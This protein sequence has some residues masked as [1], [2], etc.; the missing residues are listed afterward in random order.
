MLRRTSLASV[1]FLQPV[2]QRLSAARLFAVLVPAPFTPPDALVRRV[3]DLVAGGVDVVQLDL[4]GWEHADAVGVLNRCLPVVLPT[5]RLLVVGN[6][7]EVAIDLGADAMLLGPAQNLPAQL[8]E[9]LGA[10]AALGREVGDEVQLRGALESPDLAFVVLIGD[11]SAQ[12]A[13]RAHQ[14][15]PLAATD[16]YTDPVGGVRPWFVDL[17]VRWT[18]PAALPPRPCRVRF[19]VGVPADSPVDDSSE[20]LRADVADLAARLGALWDDDTE[21]EAV[22]EQ[23][24]ADNSAASTTFEKGSAAVREPVEAPPLA[25]GPEGLGPYDTETVRHY[26]GRDGRED[27]LPQR[28]RD[29]LQWAFRRGSGSR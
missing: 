1:T 3:E 10:Q 28:V 15:A 18:D 8:P 13:E 5:G 6:D 24:L 21:L 29:F 9:R 25:T 22:R 26:R 17:G 7:P 16:A 19:H 27:G 20:H 4:T 23:V 14:L 2:R 11:R 12:V